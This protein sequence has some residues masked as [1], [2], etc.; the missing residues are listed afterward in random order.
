MTAEAMTHPCSETELIAYI[1]QVII[2]AQ[3]HLQSEELLNKSPDI[4]KAAIEEYLLQRIPS[5]VR[6]DHEAVWVVFNGEKYPVYPESASSIF[7]QLIQRVATVFKAV[8]SVRH[9][10]EITP[11][12]RILIDAAIRQAHESERAW[13][14][15]ENI[16]KEFAEYLAEHCPELPIIIHNNGVYA[17]TTEEKNLLYLCFS[18]SAFKD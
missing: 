6:S 11:E 8:E 16:L 2:Q 5:L 14:S 1:E 7:T 9:E 13:E 12:M 3:Q 15:D 18:N 10:V 4:V 17:N